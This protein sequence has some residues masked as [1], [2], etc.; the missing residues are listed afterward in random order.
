[1]AKISQTVQNW[2]VVKKMKVTQEGILRWYSV[3]GMKFGPEAQIGARPPIG[4]GQ[5]LLVII[6]RY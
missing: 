5:Q 4:D 6:I 3:G 1:M 2:G